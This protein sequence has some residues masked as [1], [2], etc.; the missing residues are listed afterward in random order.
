MELCV[1]LHLEAL[2]SLSDI[3]DYQSEAEISSMLQTPL[4][5]SCRSVIKSHV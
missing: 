4:I 3:M 1:D 5:C 2:A